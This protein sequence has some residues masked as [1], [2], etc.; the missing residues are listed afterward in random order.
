MSSSAD[1]LSDELKKAQDRIQELEKAL[2]SKTQRSKAECA[3]ISRLLGVR[4]ASLDEIKALTARVVE[5]EGEQFQKT[6]ELVYREAEVRDLKQRLTNLREAYTRSQETITAL[7]AEGVNTTRFFKGELASANTFIGVQDKTIRE[8]QSKNAKQKEA[9]AKLNAREKRT[10]ESIRDAREDSKREYVDRVR[11]QAELEEQKQRFE[12]LS[13]AYNRSQETIAVLEAEVA[14]LHRTM[15][16][17][18][19]LDGI[20]RLKEENQKLKE[21]LRV[22]AETVFNLEQSLV[23]AW[24]KNLRDGEVGV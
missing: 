15:A 10:R 7:E 6:Q 9:L 5:L 11:A 12:R 13:A 17:Y 14:D 24:K 8:L 19:P 20:F 23:K 2:E 21:R 16:K 18:Q 1:F 4:S 3:E 22:K